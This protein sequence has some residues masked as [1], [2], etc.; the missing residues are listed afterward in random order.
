MCAFARKDLKNRIMMV[1]GG[2]L[3]AF[4]DV[5]NEIHD[6]PHIRQVRVFGRR[7][8]LRDTPSSSRS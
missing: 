2:D 5:Y 4:W 7:Q 3:K 6:R 1:N 8:A